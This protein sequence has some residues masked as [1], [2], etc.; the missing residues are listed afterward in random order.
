MNTRFSLLA[1]RNPHKRGLKDS[2]SKKNLRSNDYGNFLAK[3]NPHKRGLKV[4]SIVISLKYGHV[5]HSSQ[6]EI[7]IKED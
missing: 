7:L 2:K 4:L 5:K 3:R 1:K 6:K